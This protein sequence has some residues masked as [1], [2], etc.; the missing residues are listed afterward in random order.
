MCNYFINKIINTNNMENTQNKVS[1]IVTHNGR[2]RCLLNEIYPQFTPNVRF[3]NCAILRL[4]ISTTKGELSM[5]Y[6]GEVDCI[7]SSYKY[8]TTQLIDTDTKSLSSFTTKTYES[9][10]LQPI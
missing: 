6:P 2:L 10:E 1:I 8:Y 5:I 9:S 7:K 3:K 4:N